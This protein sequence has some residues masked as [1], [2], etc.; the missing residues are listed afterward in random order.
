LKINFFQQK[1]GCP[2]PSAYAIESLGSRSGTLSGNGD[3]Y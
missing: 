2:T 1:M 3:F